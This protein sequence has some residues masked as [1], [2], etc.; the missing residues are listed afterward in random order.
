[1][2]PHHGCWTRMLF[3]TCFTPETCSAT[4]SARRLASRE[5]TVS[6]RVTSQDHLDVR[7]INEGIVTQ[8]VAD[9]LTDA[10]IRAGVAFRPTSPVLP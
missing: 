5:S 2:L 8:A 1:M 4:S 7:G 10:V 3:C 9:I 6:V